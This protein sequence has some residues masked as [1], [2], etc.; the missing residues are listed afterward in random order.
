MRG[1]PRDY[2]DPTS[3]NYHNSGEEVHVKKIKKITISQLRAL[4][5][6][7]PI[8]GRVAQGALEFCLPQI[9]KCYFFSDPCVFGYIF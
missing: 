4:A 7:T 2:C 6:H 1:R 5:T 9:R 3:S 8:W